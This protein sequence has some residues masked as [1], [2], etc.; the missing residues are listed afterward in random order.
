MKRI[1]ITGG[2]GMLG[3]A[4]VREW[5]GRAILFPVGITQFDLRDAAA[6]GD[7]VRRLA[8]QWIIHTAAFTA[9]DLAESSIEECT[10]VNDRGTAHVAV[11]AAACGANLVYV[12]TDYVFDGTKGTPY[13]ED[14]PTSPINV[15]GRTK[16]A[17]EAHARG[18]PGHLVVRTRPLRAPASRS[19]ARSRRRDRGPRDQRGGRRHDGRHASPR[20]SPTASASSR[21]APRA[22]PRLE[23]RRRGLGRLRPRRPDE[24]G[25][26]DVPSPH[27]RRRHGPRRQ[28]PA[29]LRARRREVRRDRR[30]AQPA[31][32]DALRRCLATAARTGA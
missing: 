24:A 25:R 1:L 6:V 30:R 9:V 15:Y 18:V 8:P 11:A 14:D 19:S 21:P 26:A 2:P 12:S 7:A 17:G 23:R 20:T 3:T 16:L 29:L 22:L 13:R 31:W 27:L 28:A 4:L 5:T 10:A 32:R